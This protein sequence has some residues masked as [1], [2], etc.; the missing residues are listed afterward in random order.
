MV[1]REEG[2]DELIDEVLA[3]QATGLT[4]EEA[5]K[6]LTQNRKKAQ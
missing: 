3:L 4:I 6:K 1:W 5:F 2:R